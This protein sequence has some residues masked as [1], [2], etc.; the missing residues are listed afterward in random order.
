[1]QQCIDALQTRWA[2][3]VAVSN[4]FGGHLVPKDAVVP[5]ARLVPSSHIQG[6]QVPS[7]DVTAFKMEEAARKMDYHA[8]IPWHGTKTG[9]I[10]GVKCF[11]QSRTFFFEERG[12]QTGVLLRARIHSSKEM[13]FYFYS[14][15]FT[16]SRRLAL[17]LTDQLTGRLCT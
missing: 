13:V 2:S 3:A 17:A 6:R 7:T 12:G 16:N 1:M 14:L 8:G 9:T 10:M 11:F 5:G 15:R 4:K